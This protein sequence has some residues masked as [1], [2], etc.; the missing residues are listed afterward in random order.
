MKHVRFALAVILVPLVIA[1]S[2]NFFNLLLSLGQKVSEN[3]LPFWVGLGSYFLFQAVLSRPVRT[4][5]FGHELTHA[6]VGLCCG[7]KLKS[8][9]VSASGGSVVL[10]KTNILIALAPYFL[11][12]YTLII[13]FAY[14]AAGKFWGVEGFYPY[15]LFLVGFSLSFHLSLTWWALALGQSDLKV[16]GVFF[17]AVLILLVNFIVLS[18]LFRMLFPGQ[19]GIRGYYS[20]SFSKMILIWTILLTQSKNLWDIFR[21]TK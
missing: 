2:W 5:V 17:S 3:V 14:W 10:S 6:L 18:L 4:Y 8:F 12:L 1:L 19:V 16:F 9:K 13:F 7:A 21:S 15:F 20:D 11:P